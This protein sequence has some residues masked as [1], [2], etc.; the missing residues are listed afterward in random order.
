MQK[1]TAKDAKIVTCVI[2]TNNV[3]NVA[4]GFSYEKYV[5]LPDSDKSRRII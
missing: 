3:G 1:K 4:V 2:S 5:R